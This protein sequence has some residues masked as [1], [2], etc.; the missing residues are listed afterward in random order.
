M[1]LVVKELAFYCQKK[2]L[3][4][5]QEMNRTTGVKQFCLTQVIPRLKAGCSSTL[6]NS[7]HRSIHPN[8]CNNCCLNLKFSNHLPQISVHLSAY[9]LILLSC[10]K[11]YTKSVR[12][13]KRNVNKC[14][15]LGCVNRKSLRQS[16]H[17]NPN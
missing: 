4:N 5:M 13:S 17:F 16:A 11:D 3:R 8:L 9:L 7:M 1:L 10:M 12:C 6:H 2:K 15:S 14:T